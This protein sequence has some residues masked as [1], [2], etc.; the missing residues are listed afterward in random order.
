MVLTK[1]M[2]PAPVLLVIALLAAGL[3]GLC[4]CPSVREGP[5][6]TSTPPTRDSAA[7]PARTVCL[8]QPLGALIWLRRLGKVA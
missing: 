6:G 2:V 5:S 3:A 4:L 7:A 1:L 8:S